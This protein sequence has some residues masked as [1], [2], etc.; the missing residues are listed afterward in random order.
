MAAL[1]VVALFWGNCLSCP[2]MIL[3]AAARQ[4]AHS[5]CHRTKPACTDCH[6]Q[7]LRHFVKADP[8]APAALAVAE[9]VEP[10]SR[11]VLPRGAV[12]TPARTEHAPPDLLSL[13]SIFRI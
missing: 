8:Q 9:L 4:P 11:V 6:S 12:V 10:V 2:E 13:H 3:A 7:G 5:C 1:V